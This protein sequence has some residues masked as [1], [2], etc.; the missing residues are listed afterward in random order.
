MRSTS[1]HAWPNSARS[2]PVFGALPLM[3]RVASRSI[4]RVANAGCPFGAVTGTPCATRYGVSGSSGAPVSWAV[5]TDDGAALAVAVG[6]AVA[7]A[8]GAVLPEAAASRSAVETRGMVAP[9]ARRRANDVASATAPAFRLAGSHAQERRPVRRTYR[10]VSP[11]E[12]ARNTS[13][14][15]SPLLNAPN[16]IKRAVITPTMMV[17]TSGLRGGLGAG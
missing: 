15:P 6:L 5:G 10:P 1:A 13:A 14:P 11:A 2:Y 4:A 8:A 7:A 12:M 17:E 16:I 9:P 3:G